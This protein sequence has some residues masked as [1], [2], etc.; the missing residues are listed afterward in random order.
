MVEIYEGLSSSITSE[1]QLKLL[2]MVRIR[3]LRHCQGHKI[4]FC[5]YVLI[6]LG[7]S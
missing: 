7:I 6:K 5:L 1:V 2:L 4:M 3:S